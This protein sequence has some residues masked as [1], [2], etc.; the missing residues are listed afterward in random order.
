MADLKVVAEAGWAAKFLFEATPLVR[1]LLETPRVGHAV[2]WLVE[3]GAALP[4]QL[5]SMISFAPLVDEVGGRTSA[6][7]RCRARRRR[8][9]G[10]RATG[11][12]LPFTLW[13][14][15]RDRRDPRSRRPDRRGM[16]GGSSAISIGSNPT[17]NVHLEDLI[18]A[19]VN[20][21]HMLGGGWRRPLSRPSAR[22]PSSARLQGQPRWPAPRGRSLRVAF[23][24][25]HTRSSEL[26]RHGARPRGLCL[27][28]ADAS[29]ARSES[30]G[31]AVPRGLWGRALANKPSRD[32][33][34]LTFRRGCRHMRSPRWHRRRP[35]RKP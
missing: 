27:G 22:A 24:P 3:R 7:P 4:D 6:R 33:G 32:A 18:R 12:S 31:G 29:A 16:D 13:P 19:R 28:R 5:G 10:R 34:A 35:F 8:R 15:R 11:L 2:L 23:S 9:P 17:G 26:G 21:R 20:R 1:R 25:L 30:N 14:I